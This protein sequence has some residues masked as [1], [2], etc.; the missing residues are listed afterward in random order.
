L[1]VFGNETMPLLLP[2]FIFSAIGQNRSEIGK[3][4]L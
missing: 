2:A 1:P 3:A 4:G